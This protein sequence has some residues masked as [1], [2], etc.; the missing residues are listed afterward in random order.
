MYLEL[1]IVTEVDGRKAKFTHPFFGVKMIGNNNLQRDSRESLARWLFAQP[2]QFI[3][4]AQTV[5]QL[6]SL[7]LPQI[8]FAGR[9]NVGK[10]SLLNALVNQKTLARVSHAPG[11][12]QQIN[13]FDLGHQCTLVDLPGYGFA[14]VSK[15]QHQLWSELITHYL[16]HSRTLARVIILIDARHPLKDSDAQALAFLDHVAIPFQVALTKV[17]QRS[18]DATLVET[19]EKQKRTGRLRHMHP[20]ILRTSGSKKIGIDELR[21][22]LLE[23]IQPNSNMITT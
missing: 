1:L 21:L 20:H 6:P 10:S 17:D 22:S 2:C 16:S 5:P 23:A 7:A 4:G 3:A 13:F 18:L 12:T 11:R 15:Q 14:R 8:A 9:S 19:L